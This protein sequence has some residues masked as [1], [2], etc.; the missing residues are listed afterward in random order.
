M[1]NMT[2]DTTKAFLEYEN[3]KIEQKEIDERMDALKP[4]IMQ[5]MNEGE[6]VEGQRGSFQ[7]RKK[8][9][10]VYS[11]TVIKAEAEL[12]A[13]K[14]REEATGTATGVD[15]IYVEYRVKKT[16]EAEE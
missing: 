6:V 13:L 10:Y 9:S 11:D 16:S 5:N 2:P 1:S 4:I 7:L 8:V 15:K 3:L 14:A 12:K